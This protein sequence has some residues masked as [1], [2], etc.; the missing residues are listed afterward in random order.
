MRKPSP[1]TEL[2]RYKSM[3]KDAEQKHAHAMAS[4]EQYRSRA[5]KAEQEVAEWKRRFD[6]LLRLRPGVQTV[7]IPSVLDERVKEMVK[8]N[9]TGRNIEAIEH[10]VAGG[11]C[12]VKADMSSW[13]ATCT[14]VLRGSACLE[15]TWL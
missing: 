3:F 5:T 4:L 1:A 2:R 7:G 6:D 9:D 10:D 12:A 8:N 14:Q 11:G 15:V 13:A